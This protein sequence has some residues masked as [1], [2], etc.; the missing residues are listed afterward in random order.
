M[1]ARDKGRGLV[2][3]L[4]GDT[5]VKILNHLREHMCAAELPEANPTKSVQRKEVVNCREDEDGGRI[6]WMFGDHSYAIFYVDDEGVRRRTQKGLKVSRTDPFGGMLGPEE[7]KKARLV[8]LDR[9]RALWNVMDKSGDARYQNLPAVLLDTPPE[10][11][12]PDAV[13]GVSSVED[14]SPLERVG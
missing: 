13:Q 11:M 6:R 4:K 3:P 14:A 2:V 7:F 1:K 10:S 12:A 8:T 5:L 9:A